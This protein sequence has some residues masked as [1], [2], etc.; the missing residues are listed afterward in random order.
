M[1]YPKSSIR[2]GHYGSYTQRILEDAK[3][4]TDEKE[5]EYLKNSM[6]NF[7]KIQFLAHN[8]D[9]VENNVIAMQLKELSKGE[10]IL[11]NPDELVSTN[12]LLRAMGL[13]V[14]NQVKRAKTNFKQKN[15]Q[16][17]KFIKKP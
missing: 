13:G 10:L 5:R 9:A 7:M 8:N 14:T 6:A 4:V 11:E 15:Q 3:N 12:T 17:K 16:K 1:D 2:Y